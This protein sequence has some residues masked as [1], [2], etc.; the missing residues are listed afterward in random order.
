MNY[1]VFLPWAKND[2]PIA[3]GEFILTPYE[4]ENKPF[5]INTTNQKLVDGILEPYRAH[6]NKPIRKALIL[7]FKDSDLLKELN[8]DDFT[9]IYNF[10]EL[11]TFSNLSSRRY[12][13]NILDEY[14]N[15]FT[16]N[17][18]VVL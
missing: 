7:S 13:D 8:E 15:Y 5:D 9:N 18:R 11:F 1:L 12:F 4:R 16:I 14:C 6:A 2:K 3:T 10:S 17:F